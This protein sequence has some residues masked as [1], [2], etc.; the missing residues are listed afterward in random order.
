[1]SAPGPD[2]PLRD[3]TDAELRNARDGAWS[4]YETAMEEKRQAERLRGI[5]MAENI[6]RKVTAHFD[7]W[8][9]IKAEIESRAS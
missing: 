8:S 6:E 3:Y 7:L 4:A 9:S 1:M 5:G 2:K